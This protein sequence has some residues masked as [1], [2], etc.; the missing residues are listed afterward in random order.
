MQ[1]KVL[2][3]CWPAQQSNKSGSVEDPCTL[4]LFL[5]IFFVNSVC[6]SYVLVMCTF[7]PLYYF[8]QV[9]FAIVII[10][11]SHNF[12]NGVRVQFRRILRNRDGNR[13]SFMS[14]LLYNKIFLTCLLAT[15]IS[16]RSYIQ[17]VTW[18]NIVLAASRG[19]N[20][21]CHAG[22]LWPVY[23]GEKGSIHPNNGS[24]QSPLVER[25]GISHI[26]GIKC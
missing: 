3:R 10:E 20:V 13:G 24:M 4:T 26:C 18:R 16:P 14:C 7:W 11:R 15:E 23:F 12:Q 17:Q 8:Q 19:Q 9:Q 5:L 21:A 6:G 2:P 25:T 22:I 1:V